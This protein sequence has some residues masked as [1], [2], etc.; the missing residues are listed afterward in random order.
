MLERRALAVGS[1]RELQS[2]ESYRED[3]AKPIFIFSRRM[4]LEI[5]EV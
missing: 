1:G 3:A 4:A 5:Q 2:E